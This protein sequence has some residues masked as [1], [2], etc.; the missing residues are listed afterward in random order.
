MELIARPIRAAATA[1]GTR[2]VGSQFI[3]LAQLRGNNFALSWETEDNHYLPIHPIIL[4]GL[5]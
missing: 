5:L 4:G 3:T 2:R 1:A